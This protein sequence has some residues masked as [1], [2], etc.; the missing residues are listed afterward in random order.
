LPGRLKARAVAHSSLFI[1]LLPVV[2]IFYSLQGE[3]RYAGVPA[4]FVRLAGCHNAC[5]WCDSKETWRTDGFPLVAVETVIEQVGAYAARTVVVTGGEPLLHP[6]D[7]LCRELQKNNFRTHLETSGTATLS[8]A[9]DW[10]CLS[11]KPQQ[12]PRPD[13]YSYADELK[14]VIAS[15]EDFARAEEN[16]RRVRPECLLFLQPEWSRRAAVVPPIIDYIRQHP[17]WRL[18]LQIHKLLNIQ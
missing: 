4:V 1:P 13:I 15:L 10:L 18:S 16:A 3:G 17:K 14:I 5:P 6:L 12:P 7:R 8:G 2:E 11:P 9:W